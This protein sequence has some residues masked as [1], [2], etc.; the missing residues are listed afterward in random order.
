MAFL[1]EWVST[2]VSGGGNFLKDGKGTLIIK[3]VSA[4]KTFKD[5]RTFIMEAYVKSSSPSGD[6][7]ENGKLL[8]PNAVGST[9]S[10]VQLLTKF[11]SA[12]GNAK[13]VCLAILGPETA[14][15]D[16]EGMGADFTELMGLDKEGYS[17]K[18]VASIMRGAEISFETHRK[19]TK[20]GSKILTIPRFS[21][22]EVTPEQIAANRKLLGD[23]SPAAVD[24]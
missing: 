12:K 1:D 9:V 5:K 24:A 15:K 13:A 6:V 23:S 11:A 3:D 10:Y 7:D 17:Q 20:D 21:Y 8:A 16:D 19:A 4:Q 14:A 2:T 22:V 18:G